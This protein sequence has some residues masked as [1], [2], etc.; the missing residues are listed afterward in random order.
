MPPRYSYWT[1]I[2]GG[3][4]TAFRAARRD[5]LLPTFAR[6]LEKHIRLHDTD[7]ANP[8][9]PPA[10]NPV[11]SLTVYSHAGTLPNLEEPDAASRRAASGRPR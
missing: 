7:P 3:L 5:E 1:I 9:Y 4:P 2:A 10:L 8:D 6:I 11:V